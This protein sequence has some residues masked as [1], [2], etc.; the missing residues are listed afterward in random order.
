MSDKI[1]KTVTV[2]KKKNVLLDT[3]IE[4]VLFLDDKGY[5]LQW[6]AKEFAK[7]PSDAVQ[8]LSAAN[9]DRYMI[10]FGT[11]RLNEEQKSAA[12]TEGLKIMGKYASPTAKLEI[13]NRKPDRHYTWKRPDE[14]LQ[15]KNMGFSVENDPS[16]ETFH[17]ESSGIRTVGVGGDTELVLMSCSMATWKQFHDMEQ[18]KALRRRGE[19]E[20]IEKTTAEAIRRAGGVAHLTDANDEKR[21]WKDTGSGE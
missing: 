15:F 12:P 18:N 1:D 16:L 6:D 13:F 4:E 21:V 14:I 5:E 3:S 7:L 2:E 9:K 20:N 8:K 10:A 17:K 19:A 11:F